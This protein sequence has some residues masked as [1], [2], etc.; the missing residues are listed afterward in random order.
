MTV[1]PRI[2]AQASADRVV[3]GAGGMHQVRETPR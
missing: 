3:V 1:R 2:S